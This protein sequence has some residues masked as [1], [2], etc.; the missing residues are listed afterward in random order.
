MVCK[1]GIK[2]DL[3]KIKIILNLKPPVNSKQVRIFLAHIGYYRKF[4]RHYS[5]ITY[6]MEE[7]L[8]AN[9]PFT[10][11]KE[12]LDAFETLKRKLVEAPILRFMNW[13]IKFHVHID[14]STIVVGAI[15]AQPGEDNMDHPIAYARR[16]FNRAENNYSTIK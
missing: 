1:E 14:A 6:P 3:A 16:K 12:C 13:S 11:N 9:A 10:W 7:L 15:L 2:V 4:I 5:D 8:K